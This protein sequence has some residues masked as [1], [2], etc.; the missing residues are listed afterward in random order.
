MPYEAEIS[1]ANPSCFLFLVDQS[2]SM[3]EIM[4]PINIEPMETPITI[5]GTTYTEQADGSTKAQEVAKIINRLLLD[6]VL[7]CSPQGDPRNYFDIGVIG[8]SGS[9]RSEKVKSV[10]KGALSN[11]D[12]VS[13]ADMADNPFKSLTE[14]QQQQGPDGDIIETDIEYPLWI[15]PSAYG[16][17]PMTQAFQLANRWLSVWLKDGKHSNAFPPIVINITDGETKEGDDP[18]TAAE[19]LMSLSTEDGNI[20][21]FNIQISCK[22][23]V[24]HGTIVFP[25][26]FDRF[27]NNPFATML[28]NISSVLPQKF[29]ESARQSGFPDVKDEGSRAFSYNADMKT[30]VSFLEIGTR[31]AEPKSATQEP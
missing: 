9:G 4:N 12:I 19:E 15:E 18:T 13:L 5:D 8:Y 3:N 10:F 6:L 25:D 14:K 7:K 24:G 21:L 16:E 26:K 27:S 30:L 23:E 2:G 20:L 11:R 22:Q 1:T 31:G 17:T 28:Y 29:A